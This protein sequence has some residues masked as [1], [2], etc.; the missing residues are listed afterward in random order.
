MKRARQEAEKW[1]IVEVVEHADE[2]P[3]VI[4]SDGAVLVGTGTH[5]KWLVFDCPCKTGHRLMLNA[6]NSRSPCWT[7]YSA[8]P[9]TIYPSVDA[10][11]GDR[12][13]HFFIHRGRVSWARERLR[14][15]RR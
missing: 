13:C 8:S 1:R 14:S 15:R 11:T 12:R 5:H 2:V 9:L 3:E 4:P 7:I 6:D 10:T